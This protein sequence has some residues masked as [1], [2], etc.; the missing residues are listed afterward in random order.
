MDVIKFKSKDDARTEDEDKTLVEFMDMI[1]AFRKEGI[2]YKFLI[3]VM[4]DDGLVH[5]GSNCYENIADANLLSDLTKAYIMEQ[6]IE[7]TE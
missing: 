5:I 1:E 4:D 7:G 6:V 2:G 3:T